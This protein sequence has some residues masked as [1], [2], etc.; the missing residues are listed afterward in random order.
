M[1]H[2]LS[3]IAAETKAP[4]TAG[5]VER[6]VAAL[7][8]SNAEYG[9]P[10]WLSPDE[11]C[12][13]A[14]DGGA[15]AALA[16]ARDMLAGRPI[17]VNVVS[18]DLRRK[19]LL[20]ADMDSTLIEQECVDE[21][22]AE[23]GLRSEVAAITERAMR[24][25][26]EFEPALRERVALFKGLPT[27]VASSILAARIAIMPG[28]S[29]LVATMRAFGAYTVLI[30]GGFTAFAEPIGNRIGFHEHRANRLECE[31]D[32][33][34]GLV[35]EPILGREAKENALLELTATLA[36][37][38]AETLAVGDGANDIGMIKKAGLGV[39]YRSKPA[40]RAVAAAVI[41]HADLTGVLFL[42]G[43]RREEF[44][45]RPEG[46]FTAA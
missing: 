5:D 21:L 36:L 2:V 32:R 33:F 41:E 7:D 9:S 39:A 11:A 34:T 1:G 6:A 28:A 23:L 40:L 35:T 37:E 17:D 8:G 45:L 20:L 46:S 42:Q 43:Y 25:E 44:V 30:S 31:G 26:I 27:E 24:G 29:V 12:D 14:F 18:S 19:K 3:L 15:D 16:A 4:L 10:D 38:T 13:I 22:A